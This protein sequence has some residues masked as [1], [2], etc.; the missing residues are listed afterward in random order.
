M[1]VSYDGEF[2]KRINRKD[3]EC[4]SLVVCK[5]SKHAKVTLLGYFNAGA[6]GECDA[7]ECDGAGGSDVG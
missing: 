2:W 3:V 1:V 5:S 6:G 7:S 4:C